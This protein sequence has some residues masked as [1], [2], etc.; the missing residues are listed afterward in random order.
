MER[1]P[2][3]DPCGRGSGLRARCNCSGSQR[4]VLPAAWHPVPPLNPL[5]GGRSKR[6][7]PGRL[8]N[9]GPRANPLHWCAQPWRPRG[10]FGSSP[11]DRSS[12][13]FRR[14]CLRRPTSKRSVPKH[15]APPRGPPAAE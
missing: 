5:A 2:S 15:P 7:P 6:A 11:V 8:A 3:G 4:P 14:A 9:E 12:R 13:R 1:S 10:P